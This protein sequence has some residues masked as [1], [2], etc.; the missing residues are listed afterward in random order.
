MRILLFLFIISI[1]FVNAE[2]ID[3][4]NSE[5]KNL[6]EKD[7]NIIDVRTQNE[8]KSNGI[9]EGS[10]L[11]SLLDKK[12]KFIFENWY[13]DFNKKISKNESVIFVCA[14]GVR[15]KYISNL[16]NKKKPDLK[17]YNLK[18]GIN[19]WIRSGNKVSRL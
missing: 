14:L 10:I 15:S 9:I 7:I 11:I 1:K 19:D 12:N 18:K 8:W 6:I 4:D 3:I 5:L 13:E 16:I 17:I 2:V